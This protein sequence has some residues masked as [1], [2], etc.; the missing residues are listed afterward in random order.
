[1]TAFQIEGESDI[2]VRNFHFFRDTMMF[3]ATMPLNF[4]FWKNRM[5]TVFFYESREG[6]ARLLIFCGLVLGT[7]KRHCCCSYIAS[8]VESEVREWSIL[9]RIYVYEQTGK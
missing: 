9:V 3:V 1:M 2:G 8:I 7:N 4:C 5:P 6:M